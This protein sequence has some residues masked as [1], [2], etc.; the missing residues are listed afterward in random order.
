MN[1]PIHIKEAL[2]TDPNLQSLLDKLADGTV[3]V[4]SPFP[5]MEIPWTQAEKDNLKSALEKI[6]I[7]K[8]NK[9]K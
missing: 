3:S 2:Q 1:N 9:K 6:Y 7:K 8:Y 5:G 4:C